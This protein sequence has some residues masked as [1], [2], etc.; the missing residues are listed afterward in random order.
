M[1]ARRYVA[2]TL[3]LAFVLFLPVAALAQAT[4][5]HL[6]LGNPSGARADPDNP[7][8]KNFLMV[9][10]LFALSYNHH[11]GTPNW[12]SWR[13]VKEDFGDTERPEDA[14]HPDLALP[15]RFA[16][17]QPGDVQHSGFD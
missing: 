2:A 9:K 17:V 3:A 13:L 8:P 5:P 6:A 11:Q 15:T 14:F 10:P 4:N 16:P 1:F 7:D 12:V